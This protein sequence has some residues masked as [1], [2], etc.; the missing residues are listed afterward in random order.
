[1]ESKKI[2]AELPFNGTTAQSNFKKYSAIDMFKC[3]PEFQESQVKVESSSALLPPEFFEKCK[4]LFP[5]AECDEVTKLKQELN[6]ALYEKAQ[7]KHKNFLRRQRAKQAK[8]AQKERDAD[9]NADKVSDKPVVRTRN[10][11]LN[12]SDSGVSVK[13]SNS[14][15]NQKNN[16]KN[17]QKNNLKNNQKTSQKT[18]QKIAQ[19]LNIQKVRTVQKFTIFKSEINTPEF[20]FR[21]P[22]FSNGLEGNFENQGKLRASTE[23]IS[24]IGD[25][26]AA[27]VFVAKPVAEARTWSNSRLNR[28][29][30]RGRIGSRS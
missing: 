4:K 5:T 28:R 26:S 6:E 10:T 13:S 22:T 17:C 8:I 20:K 7:K 14:F 2:I 24:V 29:M 19:K 9:E 27:S 15:K 21:Q 3:A 12:G 23:D 1:M 30:Q 11:S 16:Q 18:N 25:N